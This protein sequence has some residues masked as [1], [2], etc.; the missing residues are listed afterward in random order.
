VAAPEG[1]VVTAP[2]RG[3]GSGR[4]TVPVPAGGVESHQNSSAPAATSSSTSTTITTPA[5]P[6]A[7]PVAGRG[8]TLGR[9]QIGLGVP[10]SG[11]W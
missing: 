8:R 1:D 9:Q 4:G 11:A 2:D 10:G 7:G 6:D 5:H 3:V